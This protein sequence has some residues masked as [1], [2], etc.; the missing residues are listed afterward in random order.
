MSTVHATLFR[1]Q[2][3]S[4][5]QLSYTSQQVDSFAL[6]LFSCAIKLE[7]ALPLPSRSQRGNIGCPAIRS[8]FVLVLKLAMIPGAKMTGSP[9]VCAQV[10]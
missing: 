3:N 7:G 8:R 9:M 10:A 1:L 4:L 5:P 6:P 2:S